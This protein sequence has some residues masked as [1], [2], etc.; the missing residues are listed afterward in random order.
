MTAPLRFDYWR[1]TPALEEIA[2]VWQTAGPMRA[3]CRALGFA[4]LFVLGIWSFE[5]IRLHRAAA[6][7]RFNATQYSRQQNTLKTLRVREKQIRR[8]MDADDRVRTIVASGTVAARR[9]AALSNDLP[10][11]VWITAITPDAN[12]M[13]LDGQ[14]GDLSGVSNALD[15][16]SEDPI[17]GQPSLLSAQFG[18]GPAA[19]GLRFTVHLGTSGP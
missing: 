12:G 7:E 9:L 3:A 15:R 16:L 19:G 5:S 6:A 11:T 8:L 10:E 4:F 18:A 2:L 13:M 1:D 14:A 17:L